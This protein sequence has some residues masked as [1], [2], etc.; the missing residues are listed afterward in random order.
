MIALAGCDPEPDEP[1]AIAERALADNSV[2]LNSAR[3]NGWT[4]NGWTLNGEALNG[5]TL[6]GWTLNGWTLNGVALVGSSFTG[7]QTI[8]GQ[9]YTRAGQDLIGSELQLV[10]PDAQQYT[11]R[12]DDIYVSPSD[13][14][15]DLYYYTVSVRDAATGTWSSLCHDGQGQPTA[16]IAL[17]NTW[18]AVT[19]A[20][21]D[22]PGTVTLACRGGVLAKCVEWGYRPWQTATQC[23]GK[24]CTQVTLADHHQACTRMARADYC[25]DGTPHTFD[26]TPIDVYDRLKTPIQAEGTQK[27]A[28]WAVEAEWS[29]AGAVCVGD[30]LRLK[31]FDDR[32]I[33]YEQ[34]PC[35]AAISGIDKCG[36]LKQHVESRVAN[37][38]CELWTD[39]PAACAGN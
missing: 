25:G 22:A 28:N 4:L 24:T 16:A 14:T 20:R 21:V 9:T 15:G 10:G 31:M 23:I 6:N 5:W 11:L 39:D 35:L 13:P 18:N 32:G 34:P 33:P 12:F 19:G 29:P 30:E 7:T 2:A 27:Y 1:G 36:D 17:A 8:D 37:K 3:I 38:Y 26:N